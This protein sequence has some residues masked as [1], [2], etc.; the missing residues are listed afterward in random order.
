MHLYRVSV[1][2]GVNPV[3][4]QEKTLGFISARDK[5]SAIEQV[6]KQFPEYPYFRLSAKPK[7][8]ISRRIWEYEE[9]NYFILPRIC[10][11]PECGRELSK[12]NRSGY[13]KKHREFNPERFKSRRK[14]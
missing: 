13:C 6:S 12:A 9:E 4:F 10:K 5:E 8:E 2:P 3:V 7:S 11:H 14:K 1:L